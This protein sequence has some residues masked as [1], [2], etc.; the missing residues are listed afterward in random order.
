MT[1]IARAN[2]VRLD[3]EIRDIARRER[4]DPRVLSGRIADGSVVVIRNDRHSNAVPIA[5]GTGTRI[6]LR[7]TPRIWRE[8]GLERTIG[9]V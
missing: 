2:N 8:D 5:V 7:P 9:T 1:R 4:I 6:K 3:D